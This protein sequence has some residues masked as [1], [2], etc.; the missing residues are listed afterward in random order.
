MAMSAFQDFRGISAAQTLS[1]V[2]AMQENGVPITY[3]Y[4]SDAH[5][6]HAHD[7]ATA[8][9][10][11]STDPEL[12]IGNANG[13]GSICY[14][15]Q[16]VAYNEAFGK[17]F[18]RL[19][20]D[21]INK[22]NTL[23]VITADEGDHYA[24]GGP[25]NSSCD[26]VTIPCSYINPATG[27]SVVGEFDTNLTG[28]MATEENITSTF[29]IQTDMVPVFYIEG[30]PPVGDPLARSF[31][32]ASANLTAVNPLTGATDNLTEALADPVEL[33][34]LH[35]VT[36][37]PQR[38]P[39]FVM[40]GNPDYFHLTGAP[41][42]SKACVFQGNGFA[43]NHGGIDKEIVTTFLGLVGPGIV[44]NGVDNSVWSDHVDIRATMLVLTGLR[45]D[46]QDDG[47]AL[48]EEFNPWALPKGLTQG[49]GRFG[50]EFIELARAYKQINAPNGDL[51][52]TSLRIS[53]RALASGSPGS[54]S[55]YIHV[56][57]AISN[58][59]T[60]RDTLAAQMLQLLQDAEF[61]GKQIPP[62]RAEL[63]TFQAQILL[64]LT[65]LL[66]HAR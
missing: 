33:K 31:E 25:F 3:A 39:S 16:L 32:R 45:D 10:A 51:G 6:N 17:F 59:T 36:G 47:R 42:C 21:G 63:L 2:A 15:A 50:N 19:A 20:A 12:A 62:G 30:N 34:L 7:I 29:D 55:Q 66:D 60:A 14:E 40:F 58:I 23:F 35:M 4:I 28:L 22:Q 64:D 43:W 46:Y 27:K 11:C 44:T 54:D 65:H 24:G 61:N 41:N 5:D 18:S 8:P 57:N 52:Q 13:P 56:E 26:G 53:T 37:D 49:N 9:A 1:Y 48:V 38:T